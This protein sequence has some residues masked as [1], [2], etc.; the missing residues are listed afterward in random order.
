MRRWESVGDGSAKFWE[1]AAEDDIVTVRY[2]RVGTEGRTQ[3]KALESA[4]AAQRYLAKTIAEK[5]RK[6]YQEVAAEAEPATTAQES[7][8][9]VF[10]DEETF[11]MPAAW[12]RLVYPRRGGIRRSVGELHPEAEELVALRLKEEAGWVEQ[13]LSAPQSDPVIVEATRAHLNGSHNPVGA[14]TL[15]RVTMHFQLPDG[16]FVD[17]WIRAHGMA[18]AARA[19]VEFFDIETHY[20]Q[21]G[22]RREDPWLSWLPGT[23]SSDGH[24]GRPKFADRM[25]SLLTVADEGTYRQVVAALAHCRDSVRRRIVVSYLVPGEQDWVTEC[26]ADAAT[27]GAT[28]RAM[29]LCSLNSP[30][31]LDHFGGKLDLGWNGWSMPLV[32]T[33]AEGT[34]KAFAPLLDSAIGESYSSD[35]L[36]AFAGALVELPTDDAFRILLAR[37]KNK[38]VRPNLLEAMRRYPVR[39]LRLLGA[40]SLGSAEYASMA[41]Q[42]LAAHVRTHPD[43]V[44]AALPDLPA[45]VAALVEP[46]LTRSDRVAE[47]PAQA[48]PA[49]LVAPPWA[50]KRTARKARVAAEVP[51]APKPQVVWKPGEQEA[52]A[53]VTSWYGRWRGS[54]D[55]KE[56]I[57]AL[58][59]GGQLKD[60]REVRLFVVGPEEV[61]R[62]LLAVCAPEDFWDGEA[63]LKPVAAK[64]GV[65]AL[66]LLLHAA[67]RHPATLGLLL[68]PYLDVE[69]A[70]QV[71]DWL[72]RLKSADATGRAWLTRHGP[73]A[74]PVLVPHAV[75]PVG[76]V[77]R[78]AEKALRLLASAH[79]DEAVLRAA[80]ECGQEAADIV[81]ELLAADPLES[82]LP[83]RMPAVGAWAA[84]ALLPQILLTEGGAL[85][86]DAVRHVL[87]VLALSK[88][89]EVYPGLDV[90]TTHCTGDS[91]AAFAWGLFEQWRLA[92]M[93]A[94][95]SWALHAL[96]LLGDDETVRRLT[97]LV[98]AWPG[99]G[100]HHRAVEGLNVLATIGTDVALLHL[101]GIAQRVPFK[102]LKVRAQEKIAEVAEGLGLTAEQLGDRLVPDFGL[103]ADGSTVI[104]YGPRSF[105][106]GFDEQ[107]R[108]Y[109][110]DTDG[111]PR[112]ALP[113]PGAK[114]DPELAPAERKRFAAL[115]KDVR[116]VAADQVRRLEA[117]MVAQRTWTASEFKELFLA[118]PLLWHLVRRLVW[119]GETDGE[120]TAFRVAE[121]RT[122]ADMNDDEL[123]LP[124]EASVRL[125]HPL[126]LGADLDTWSELFADYKILQPFPQLGR[127]VHAFTE[128]EAAGHRLTR[129]EGA[130]VPV[131]KLLGLTKRGWERGEP[132]DAGVERWFHRRIDEDHYLV[133]GL[134]E[135]IAVGVVDMFPDQT[136]ETVWLDSSPGDYRQSHTHPLRF[137]DLDPV[138]AS[139]LLADLTEV[140]AK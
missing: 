70:G 13:M 107:L 52:W 97:P 92:G 136:F 30:A 110:R 42:L 98:R 125:A 33:L 55:W 102:A 49:L 6:G 89:G 25:R 9:V 26:C 19:V 31:Q 137:G 103:D 32:A 2:G 41:E 91:L 76:T 124:Q 47:A 87:T 44:A 3:V 133:I 100:A 53:A 94:K 37:V 77:R 140:T 120:V 104:D 132:Q 81:A 65:D 121:D 34:G 128:K 80:A 10:P 17:A 12:R 129:F 22:G 105:T 24:W 96:G 88:P 59:R 7:Q 95:D 75:G 115:K 51:V 39:A 78:G 60:V 4:E 29:L 38:H 58:Q 69:V 72:A 73:A 61:V 131:G 23:D 5:E 116:T 90:L 63:A 111:K 134:D 14:A 50:K 138:I 40:A 109:V 106:V 117:A 48:L 62:P 20:M 66:P 27:A 28:L 119:I 86:A 74:V 113:A 16:V 126:H 67:A 71:C 82:A 11:S 68:L 112:K 118:H 85:P 21:Y 123:T 83:A 8:A 79:G 15:A 43:L 108:P 93:P 101:H 46:L 35:W 56:E 130:T 57:K 122:F 18:F 127:A 114:D 84:P 99:E 135:G 45:E 64:Y 1:A 54:Y 139:E 36:K